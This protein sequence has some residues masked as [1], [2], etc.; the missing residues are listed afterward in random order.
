M[1]G[2]MWRTDVGRRE[3]DRCLATGASRAREGPAGT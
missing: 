1:T 2:A 3:D